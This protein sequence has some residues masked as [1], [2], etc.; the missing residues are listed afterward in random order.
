VNDL[1]N[2]KLGKVENFVVDMS[3]GRIVAVIISSGGYMG[4]DIR[5][6]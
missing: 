1:Q 2:E 4:M 3:C 6:D 5:F